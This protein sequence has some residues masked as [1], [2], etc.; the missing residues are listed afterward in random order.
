M[1][2][3][4]IIFLIWIISMSFY[5]SADEVKQRLFEQVQKSN[6]TQKIDAYI[7]YLD[8]LYKTNDDASLQYS[9]ELKS[10]ATQLDDKKGLAYAYE[11]EGLYYSKI[12]DLE[13]ALEVLEKSK[14]YFSQLPDKEKYLARVLSYMSLISGR[15]GDINNRI[16]LAKEAFKLAEQ[17][18]DHEALGH[19]Y[20]M[21]GQLERLSSN[22][23]KTQEY[24]LKS[25][26]HYKL[27]NNK[28]EAPSA[29]ISYG[30]FMIGYDFEKAAQIFDEAIS[31]SKKHH[32]KRVLLFAL[33][34]MSEVCKKIGNQKKGFNVAFERYQLANSFNHK[35]QMVM[36]AKDL[37]YFYFLYKDYKQARDYYL[38]SLTKAEEF[39]LVWG[40]IEA[41]RHLGQLEQELGNFETAVEYQSESV[42]L[43]RENL[44]FA[45]V[46]EGLALLGNAYIANNQLD[47][48][49]EV[50]QEILT[51]S[52]NK[53]THMVYEAY[54]GIA[55]YYLEKKLY[56]KAINYA[57]KTYEKENDY[58]DFIIELKAAK[59]LAKCFEKK[60][61]YEKVVNYERLVNS[62]R[63][64]INNKENI[65]DKIR[66]TL[67]FEFE[68]QQLLDSLAFVEIE[69]VKDLEISRHKNRQYAFFAFG[70]LMLI[71]AG[72]FLYQLIQTKK[73]RRKSQILLR[74]LEKL[75]QTKDRLFSIIGHDLRKPA[76]AFRG[77]TKKVNY[78]L[79]KKDYQTLDA[80]GSEIEQ[81]A[82][83]LN[84][85]TDNLL[86][87]ALT[88][89]DMMPY[90][91]K[92]VKLS[93]VTNE[94]ET[95]FGKVAKDKNI[96]FQNN[97]QNGVEVFADSNA[98]N[99]IL[100]NLTDN[101]LK[102]TPSGGK[103]YLEAREVSADIEIQVSD[104]GIGME[105][106]K[107][108]S[109]FEL[110]KNKSQRGTA[111][112]KGTGLGL[113]LVHELVK[114]NKGS[115]RVKSTLG[116]GTIFHLYLPKTSKTN[117]NINT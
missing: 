79:K 62:L 85:L 1:R 43:A 69:K 50:F 14:D 75:N 47:K 64:S 34:G 83:A 97:I 6:G 3:S 20:K 114:L 74:E 25:I 65:E 76:I 115:I 93:E 39:N 19:G 32:N 30:Y 22:G 11:Y 98:L 23:E 46:L 84:T 66:L 60:R 68:K 58:R 57:S 38:E 92:M 2:F 80:L 33:M 53:H 105:A 29:M 94:L 13:K 99:T 55:Q 91:P 107:L 95:I 21:L 59:I 87:W 27:S 41:F 117:E 8:I 72:T 12:G 4:F 10:F 86:N 45:R 96:H 31:L 37:G 16:N 15:I 48:A 100:R 90:T 24:L 106:S 42:C 18:Q 104:T 63:D 102:Y 26:H 113:H 111:D 54:V 44:M 40:K 108:E 78:L 7:A 5:A 52:K 88:Q 9:N 116:K 49:Y 82:S 61:N 81:Q 89:K 73:A 36:S 17:S 35:F 112:E 101:A 67:N 51:F 28:G 109:L 110:N 77:I 56:D 71:G 103:V 70:L